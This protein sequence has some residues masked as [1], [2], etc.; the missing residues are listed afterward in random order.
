MRIM[1]LVSVLALLAV[2]FSIAFGGGAT[3]L[4]EPPAAK[5]KAKSVLVGTVTQANGNQIAVQRSGGNVKVASVIVVADQNTVIQNKGQKTLFPQ[6]ANAIIAS[7]RVQVKGTLQ[8]DGS[9]LASRIL[10]QQ[11]NDND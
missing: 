2:V 8:Q 4:A 6:G 11:K 9:L 1:R 3:A 10:I 7:V 5:S